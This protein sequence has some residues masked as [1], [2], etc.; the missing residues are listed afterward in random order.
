MHAP[1]STEAPVATR[2]LLPGTYLYHA[3]DPCSL[4]TIDSGAIRL[5]LARAGGDIAIYFA[6]PGDRV[7]LE[8]L[9]VLS[10]RL[11]ARA[12]TACRVR[13]VPI[14]GRDRAALL[15]QS[16]RWQQR[17]SVDLVLLKT[18]TLA[19][20]LRHLLAMIATKD[21]TG[22]SDAHD[23]PLPSLKDLAAIVG[24]APESVSRALGELR[25]DAVVVRHR[26]G[27]VVVE[28]RFLES[29][30]CP[31]RIDGRR[32]ARAAPAAAAAATGTV[33]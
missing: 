5:D 28:R 23:C 32:R 2:T 33:A 12:V 8:S 20:R 27:S 4:W 19:D 7:G 22:P 25:R 17:K 13:R 9:D 30:E 18:G 31:G 6:G 11:S 16:V 1:N 14:A 15:A 3:G 21:A 26:R 29:R 24:A 10:Q